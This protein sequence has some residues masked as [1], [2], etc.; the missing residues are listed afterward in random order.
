MKASRTPFGWNL[1][2]ATR[3]YTCHGCDKRIARGAKAYFHQFSVRHKQCL[4]VVLGSDSG[5]QA[6]KKPLE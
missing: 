5:S 2:T 1:D 4:L 3:A 6:L